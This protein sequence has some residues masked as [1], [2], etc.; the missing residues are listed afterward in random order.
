MQADDRGSV[1]KGVNVRY[2]AKR[3]LPWGVFLQVMLGPKRVRGA[4]FFATEPEAREAAGAASAEV[5]ALL[6]EY[7]AAQARRARLE[8]PASVGPLANDDLLLH[9]AVG[10]WQQTYVQDREAA[11][12][13]S[14]EGLMKNH[15]LPLIGAWPMT[16]FITSKRCLDFYEE[17]RQHGVRLPTRR[18]V[19][20]CLRNFFSWAATQDAYPLKLNPAK[21]IGRFIRHKSEKRLPT[22]SPNPMTPPQYEAFLDWIKVHRP[23]WW[24]FFLYLGDTG[25]RSGEACALKK[26]R[27]DLDRGKAHILESWSPSQRRAERNTGLEGVGLKDTRTHR[28]PHWIDLSARLV[29]ALRGLQHRQREDSLRRGRKVPEFVFTSRNGTPRTT[30]KGLHQVFD[31]ACTALGLVGETGLKFTP[32]CLRDTFATTHIMKHHDIGWVSLMLGHADEITTRTKY[33]KWLRL[34]ESRG[35]ADGIH[36]GGESR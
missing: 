30:E 24:E 7:D 17:L 33:Y 28:E 29:T 22:A 11:T 5:T 12:A 15:I 26:T 2:D 14:Y 27:V 20:A 25:C 8:P 35:F 1:M 32:H 6:A 19:H 4:K 31:D 3:K 9:S 10:L 16:D 36:E 21:G 18:H 23:A 34:A 13:R